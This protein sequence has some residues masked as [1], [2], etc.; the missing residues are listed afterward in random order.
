MTVYFG[1]TV[2]SIKMPF[3]VMGRVGPKTMY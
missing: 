2:V 3:E 1:R